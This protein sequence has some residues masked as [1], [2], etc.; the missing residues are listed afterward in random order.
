LRGGFGL[1]DG[2]GF[3]LRDGGGWI[4]SYHPWEY[5]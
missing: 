5:F 1:R 4:P 3:G 2:F